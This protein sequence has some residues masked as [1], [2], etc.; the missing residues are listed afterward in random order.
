M[1]EQ[2]FDDR[3]VVVAEDGVVQRRLPQWV[4]AFGPTPRSR[5]HLIA[6]V[7]VPVGLAQ[8]HRRQAGVGQLAALDEDFSAA[9]S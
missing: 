1:I 7:V 4:E 6:V 3:E 5:S 9:L 8:Q 2:E